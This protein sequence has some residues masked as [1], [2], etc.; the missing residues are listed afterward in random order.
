MY[1]ESSR[2]MSW[3]RASC[4]LPPARYS[5]TNTSVL[6]LEKT[7]RNCSRQG[8]R[9][10]LALKHSRLCTLQTKS[11]ADPAM[12]E[13]SV[14]GNS[15]DANLDDVDVAK[16][17]QDLNLPSK[18][19]QFLCRLVVH[20]LAGHDSRPRHARLEHLHCRKQSIQPCYIQQSEAV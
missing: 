18:A 8:D 12:M 9:Q 13:A 14:F 15:A 7:P 3:P 4:R 19:G 6:P 5:V 2:C 1:Q 20:H 10:C 16:V 11:R 17:L